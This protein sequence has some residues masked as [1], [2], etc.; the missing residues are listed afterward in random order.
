MYKEFGGLLTDNEVKNV[1]EDNIIE[2]LKI[3]YAD[4]NGINFRNKLSHGYLK[5]DEFN[6]RNS[7]AV[8]F[9]LLK[10]VKC[11]I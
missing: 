9:A 4:I 2:Y 10:L 6:H 5:I 1:L 8:I 3:K 7:F 11:V